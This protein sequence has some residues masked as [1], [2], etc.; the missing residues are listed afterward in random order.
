MGIENVVHTVP[1]VAGFWL[2]DHRVAGVLLPDDQAIIRGPRQAGAGAN[3]MIDD[4]RHTLFIEEGATG[5]DARIGVTR[6]WCQSRGMI[7]P[8]QQIGTGG[9]PPAV[10]AVGQIR[11]LEDVEQVVA[12]PPPDGTVG[13]EGYRRSFRRQKVPARGVWVVGNDV[14]DGPY[15]L[16]H[17]HWRLLAGEWC[18]ATGGPS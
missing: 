13:V 14:G 6:R 3:A 5:K 16:L 11:I 4:R 10:P 1:G 2:R 9:V 12:T 18:S 15:V 7:L 17:G 8:V